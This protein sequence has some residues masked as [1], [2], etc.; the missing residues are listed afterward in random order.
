MFFKVLL[1]LAL[2]SQSKSDCVVKECLNGGFFN[3][4]LCQCECISNFLFPS[5][6]G[7]SG[8]FCEK[9]DCSTQAASCG[10]T[11]TP[12]LCSIAEI[13]NYC[14][15][16]CSPEVCKCGFYGCINNGTFDQQ[17]CICECPERFEGSICENSKKCSKSCENLGLINED[18]CE[19][20][21]FPNFTGEKCENLSCDIPDSSICVPYTT[22]FCSIK[23]IEFYCPHLCLKC[24]DIPANKTCVENFE[25]LN[26]G[27]WNSDT[28]ECECLSSTKGKKCETFICEQDPINTCDNADKCFVKEI[29]DYCP[30]LCGKCDSV[31]NNTQTDPFN[32]EKYSVSDAFT[33]SEAS[34]AN[35][36]PLETNTNTQ[37]GDFS[38]PSNQNAG[39]TTGNTESFTQI[40]ELP[41]T[42]D[43]S[44]SLNMVTELDQ[45]STDQSITSTDQNQSSKI[46]IDLSTFI[47][48]TKL[49]NTD[50]N[51]QSSVPFTD[52][53][54]ISF[55]STDVTLPS[56]INQRTSIDQTSDVSGQDTT[57]DSTESE[58]TSKV[59]EAS[60]SVQSTIVA[61]ISSESG[62]N[63]TEL[64]SD[65]LTDSS[66]SDLETKIPTSTDKIDSTIE[67]SDSVQSTIVASISS[68]SGQNP[69]E[70]S[71]DKLT[72]FTV[73][74]FEQ[75]TSD[76]WDML[77]TELSSGLFSELST[78]DEFFSQSD[79]E[80][81]FTEE[82]GLTTS[83]SCN[84]KCGSSGIL[85]NEN[86]SCECLPFYT[87]KF[88]EN[89]LCDKDPE[90]CAGQNCK[91]PLVEQFCPKLCNKC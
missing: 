19:C 63:P 23:E 20:D 22:D 91:F 31:H 42:N 55:F 11:L 77:N 86:C 51:Y 88:C 85:V 80:T 61:S 40:S 38:R 73:S 24:P 75:K 25:C 7:Y 58:N 87:G 14:P 3:Q 60:D 45:K 78:N 4:D 84:I 17:N 1:L 69:T 49:P 28:C 50:Q 89:P 57:K 83:N 44:S 74:E 6:F 66:V 72:D 34:Q 71:S 26:S 27:K 35:N 52:D 48:E 70:L 46:D 76:N 79:S 8:N 47:D 29:Q 2:W 90:L 30:I 62:Q 36:T 59:P 10:I 64:S 43:D 81:D 53:S 9:I 15:L 67:A 39:G 65:K 16:M 12:D 41:G 54:K 56:G 21:C 68:E 33:P 37:T 18:T 32:T 5:Y 82:N 13:G